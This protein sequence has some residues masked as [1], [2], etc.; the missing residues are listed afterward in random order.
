MS[1]AAPEI[2]CYDIRG[3]DTETHLVGPI[4]AQI[5]DADR[6]VRTEFR[7]GMP[8]WMLY[9]TALA[10]DSLYIPKLRHW[11]IAFTWVLAING[12]VR[13]KVI[14]EEFIGCAALD[15]LCM[16]IHGRELQPYTET[17]ELVGVHHAT[18]KRL[19]DGVFKR[20]KLSLDEYWVQLITASIRIKFYERKRGLTNRGVG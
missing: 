7:N 16:V 19:R 9:R 6:L 2:H 4:T 11:V 8:N 10:G 13:R 12:G 17:A 15:A 18:Y 3:K 5:I 20:L 1:T 14:S